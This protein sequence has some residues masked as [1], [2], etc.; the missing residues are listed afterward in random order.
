MTDKNKKKNRFNFDPP[1]IFT[2]ISEDDRAEKNA[3]LKDLI[4]QTQ[5]SIGIIPP[6]AEEE[7]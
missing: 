7:K 2:D 6:S 4:R 3:R 1:Q 5:I